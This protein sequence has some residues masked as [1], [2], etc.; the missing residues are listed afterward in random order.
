M[1]I[2][3]EHRIKKMKGEKRK[4]KRIK[5]RRRIKPTSQICSYFRFALQTP[6]IDIS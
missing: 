3:R 1:L 2:I 4:D 5:A 6:L